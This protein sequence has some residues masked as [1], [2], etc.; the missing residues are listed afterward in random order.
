MACRPSVSTSPP[1][2]VA[3]VGEDD[4]NPAAPRSALDV[5]HA[6]ENDIA[7]GREQ[8]RD[9]ES[10][11]QEA[12]A[13]PDDQT[14]DYAFARAALAGRLAE[15]RGAGAG[16]LVG[17][18]ERWARLA[19]QRDPKDDDGAAT[20]MLGSLYV[21]APRR[22]V[23]HGDAE[24]GL[25]MLES[26]AADHPEEPRNHLRLAEALVFSGD[27]DS[28]RDPLCMALRH[29]EVF[30]PDEQKLLAS[31]VEESGGEAELGCTEQP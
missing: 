25:S 27:V 11:Y 12:A 20:R 3:P 26:L 31:L 29:R 14:A 24:V 5:L 16:K 1:P 4:T 15:R 21:M 8:A 22:L 18:A 28:A 7:H 17:E 10:A 6:L 2:V 30:R 9:R 23:E 13:L 19:L